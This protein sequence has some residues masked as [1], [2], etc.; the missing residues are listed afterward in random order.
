MVSARLIVTCG[1]GMPA[2]C[3]LCSTAAASAASSRLASATT[4]MS[5]P[6]VVW[7]TWYSRTCEARSS[8]VASTEGCTL[9]VR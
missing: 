1:S 4:T 2:W 5:A 6:Q 8:G 9:V 3:R 7:R